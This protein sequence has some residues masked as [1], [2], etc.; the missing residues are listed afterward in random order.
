MRT[1]SGEGDSFPG[2]G[3]IHDNGLT[4]NR[5]LKKLSPD[6]AAVCTNPP[7]IE[8]KRLRFVQGID[9]PRNLHRTLPTCRLEP[10]IG[11]YS[12]S[13]HLTTLRLYPPTRMHEPLYE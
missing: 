2:F 1:Q 12:Y 3:P 4:E 7:L 6:L 9:F 11:L 8:R 13:C 10:A 5:S